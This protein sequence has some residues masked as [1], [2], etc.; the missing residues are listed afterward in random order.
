MS[1]R[2]EA[3][4]GEEKKEA[5]CNG[6]YCEAYQVYKPCCVIRVVQCE[7]GALAWLCLCYENNKKNLS[8]L[9]MP[10]VKHKKAVSKCCILVLS[11]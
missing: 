2:T 4:D 8:M 5:P 7:H 9:S 11:V 6:E 10:Q 3:F 1:H